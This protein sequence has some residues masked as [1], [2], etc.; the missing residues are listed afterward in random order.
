MHNTSTWLNQRKPD[1]NLCEILTDRILILTEVLSEQKRKPI[2]ISQDWSWVHMKKGKCAFPWWNL[3][4][5][6]YLEMCHSLAVH[7]CSWHVVFMFISW[8][9]PHPCLT[10]ALCWHFYSYFPLHEYTMLPPHVCP[11][12][13]FSLIFS[14]LTGNRKHSAF[15]PEIRKLA[16]ISL[17]F[18]SLSFSLSSHSHLLCLFLLL[19]PFLFFSQS[20]SFC[21]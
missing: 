17:S 6:Q 5:P 9:I 19:P 15:K 14:F 21:C 3:P 1:F 8:C 16:L 2:Q 18:P 13:G 20:I 10:L 7:F 11:F 12:K 4:L